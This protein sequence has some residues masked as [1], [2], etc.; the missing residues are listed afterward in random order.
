MHITKIVNSV[1]TSNTFILID[2]NSLDCWLVDVGDIE[3][4]LE[5]VGDKEVKG[6]FITH[7]HYDHIYGINKLVERFP[8]CIIYTS[9]YGKEGLFSDKLNFSRYHADPI[10]FQG[11]HIEVLEEG[12][13]ISL[14]PNVVL[15][16]MYTPGHDWSSMSYYTDGVIFTGDSYIPNI[17]VVTSLPKSNKQEA[18][19]SLDRILELCEN[20]DIY[21]GHNEIV[22]RN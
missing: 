11:N 19:V 18:Q 16:T 5:A 8:D 17:K 7:T 21:P 10:L 3:P 14:F 20:R 2:E 15:R 9:Q 22:K 1:F 12:D 13:E 4:I 6:I